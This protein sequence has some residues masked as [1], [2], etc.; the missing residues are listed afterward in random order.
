MTIIPV[1]CPLPARPPRP[2]EQC[3]PGMRMREQP[4]THTACYLVSIFSTTSPLFPSTG[5]V[6]RGA[7]GRTWGLWGCA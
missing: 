2:L 3:L 4:A 5:E 7:R 1:N 6:A